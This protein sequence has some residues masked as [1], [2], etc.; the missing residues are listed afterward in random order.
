MKKTIIALSAFALLGCA[1][2]GDIIPAGKNTYLVG[3]KARGGLRSWAT[4][5][6]MA[7][8]D[9]TEFCQE[10]KL[11]MLPV[12]ISTHGVRGLTPQ[13]ADLTF[14]CLSDNDP[15]WIN[16]PPFKDARG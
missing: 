1:G 11:N 13:E 3:A 14:K 7:L 5:K 15:E 12:E 10:K 8:N 6:G 16:P 4:I 9:A 2:T